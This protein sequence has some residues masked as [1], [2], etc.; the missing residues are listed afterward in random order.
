MVSWKWKNKLNS[1]SAFYTWY[2]GKKYK[3]VLVFLNALALAS[4]H[5]KG[6]PWFIHPSLVCILFLPLGWLSPWRRL[7]LT[8]KKCCFWLPCCLAN[9][10]LSGLHFV[11]LLGRFLP[12]LKTEICINNLLL[13]DSYEYPRFSN[14]LMLRFYCHCPRFYNSFMLHFSS[15]CQPRFSLRKFT[16]LLIGCPRF[17]P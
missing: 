11:L 14:Y 9:S 17:F 10:P 7:C 5:W 12:L 13:L 6:K 2:P 16:D 1:L 8:L 4:W 3:N 15:Y